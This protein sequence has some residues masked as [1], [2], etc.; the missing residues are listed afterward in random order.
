MQAIDATSRPG[1]E[2]DETETLAIPT[3]REPSPP[4]PAVHAHGEAIERLL[5]E[6]QAGVGPAL[7]P[8]VASLVTA[9]VGLYGAGLERVLA[10]ARAAARSPEEL[11]AC[12]LRDD[13]VASLLLLHDLH[14]KSL[15]ERIEAALD[16]LR[17]ELPSAAGLRLR[18]VE[19][20]IVKLR[21]EGGGAPDLHVIARAIEGEAP[22]VAG[23]EVEAPARPAALLPADRLRR[24]ARP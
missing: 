12:V 21:N 11:E 2:G 4:P 13:L 15:E 18:A 9:L 23:V 3:E 17:T 20:G 24:G 19:D 10:A 6:V 22:E 1:D 14:P 16:R 5:G 8:R 7:W